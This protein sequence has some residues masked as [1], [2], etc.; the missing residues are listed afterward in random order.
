MTE[1]HGLADL[2]TPAEALKAVA[3]LTGTLDARHFAALAGRTYRSAAPPQPAATP[4]PEQVPEPMGRAKRQSE[5]EHGTPLGKHYQSDDLKDEALREAEAESQA[6]FNLSRREADTEQAWQLVRSRLEPA[7]QIRRQAQEKNSKA[8]GK[9]HPVYFPIIPDTLFRQI[10]NALIAKDLVSHRVDV[11]QLVKTVARGRVV[12]VPRLRR[13]GL[14]GGV[15]IIR[16]N[17]QGM[18]PFR[19][20]CDHLIRCAREVLPADRLVLGEFPEHGPFTLPERLGTLRCGTIIL[21]SDLNR[22]SHTY[23]YNAPSLS[24]WRLLASTAKA[25]QLD[26]RVLSPGSADGLVPRPMHPRMFD[27]RRGFARIIPWHERLSPFDARS[28]GEGWT[29]VQHVAADAQVTVADEPERETRLSKQVLLQ[30]EALA[31]QLEL[32][33]DVDAYTLRTLRVILAAPERAALAYGV[34]GQIPPTTKLLRELSP[35]IEHQVWCSQLFATRGESSEVDQTPDHLPSLNSLSS[36]Q[37][38]LAAFAVKVLEQAR[39]T[40]GLDKLLGDRVRWDWLLKPAERQFKDDRALAQAIREIDATTVRAEAIFGKATTRAISEAG[41]VE[42]DVIGVRFH[43]KEDIRKAESVTLALDSKDA[44]VVFLCP[45]GLRLDQ[46]SIEFWPV[47]DP[48]GLLLSEPLNNLPDR[49]EIP[50]GAGTVVLRLGG[51]VRAFSLDRTPGVLQPLFRRRLHKPEPAPSGSAEKAISH[52]RERK[53][54]AKWFVGSSI[55]GGSLVFNG[56]NFDP[57]GLAPRTRP[58]STETEVKILG[59]QRETIVQSGATSMAITHDDRRL[60]FQPSPTT[61]ELRS[62]GIPTTAS[63]WNSYSGEVGAGGIL[64]WGGDDAWHFSVADQSEPDVMEVACWRLLDV[65]GQ[66]GLWKRNNYGAVAGGQAVIAYENSPGKYEVGQFR[67]SGGKGEPRFLFVGKIGERITSTILSPDGYLACGV[68]WSDRYLVLFE[69]LGQRAAARTGHSD[70]FN[71]L[72]VAPDQLD[73]GGPI[74]ATL[75]MRTDR[76]I[77]SSEGFEPVELADILG[78]THSESFGRLLRLAVPVPLQVDDLAPLLDQ[79]QRIVDA[80][81][82]IVNDDPARLRDLSLTSE[83]LSHRLLG[84]GMT[85][86]MV[87]CARPAPVELVRALVAAGADVNVQSAIGVTPLY[88]A[89]LADDWGDSLEVLLDAGANPT[90]SFVEDGVRVGALPAAMMVSSSTKRPCRPEVLER[91]MA[92]GF[93]PDTLSDRYGYNLVAAAAARDDVDI[94]AR[95]VAGSSSAD[96]NY[97]SDGEW[98]PLAVAAWHGH[99]DNV[100][101]LIEHGADIFY[102]TRHNYSVATIAISARKFEVLQVVLGAAHNLM[103][104]DRRREAFFSACLSHVF[105]DEELADLRERVLEMLLGAG[106][107]PD[108]APWPL[109]RQDHREALVAALSRSGRK[110]AIVRT[111][112]RNNA[113]LCSN[114]NWLFNESLLAVLDLAKADENGLTLAHGFA[115]AVQRFG[116]SRSKFGFNM[117]D[118][119]GK[120]PLSARNPFAV[121]ADAGV[122]LAGPDNDGYQPLHYAAAFG[123]ERAIELLPHDPAKVAAEMPTPAQL[124]KSF[125]HSLEGLGENANGE[126]VIPSEVAPTEISRLTLLPLDTLWELEDR[127]PPQRLAGMRKEPTLPLPLPVGTW[128]P[129]KRRRARLPYRQSTFLV[130]TFWTRDDGENGVSAFVESDNG[131]RLFDVN[132]TSPPIHKINVE[133]ELD[134]AESE[135]SARL[136][137]HFFCCAIHGNDGEFRLVESAEELRPHM[138]LGAEAPQVNYTIA[139]KDDGSGWS[140]KAPMIYAGTYFE[141]ALEIADTGMV[142]MPD[143]LPRPEIELRSTFQADGTIFFR[144]SG[145]KT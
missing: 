142:E 25:L 20:D 70:S 21:L 140:V 18:R 17:G 90:A 13:R 4:R 138:R 29:H 3:E 23:G 145:T 102:L 78:S 9:V 100:R 42:G 104:T 55:A 126:L 134:I 27:P 19:L 98:T 113:E 124:A 11:Q 88:P 41:T 119:Q 22:F 83:E 79:P 12:R 136:Y 117:E 106:L 97:V 52:E 54:K 60:T 127:L 53:A 114:M 32:V 63:V 120:D 33:T 91:M 38:E 44:E 43:Y 51:E 64:L 30:K 99:V 116:R 139:R 125:G 133:R 85:L 143:D 80:I 49:W 84:S 66:A 56:N 35:L 81:C 95:I 39:A 58:A 72:D 123:N 94:L 105:D 34:Q 87:A 26:V 14:R 48:E 129:R 93:A 144:T 121:L 92:N 5:I 61:S 118:A 74:H 86:L 59:E 71:A 6:P 47:E 75:R 131:E 115:A 137:L 37:R 45:P 101:F 10:L 69:P 96:I 135:T 62:V 107:D 77:A 132:G 40:R 130:E 2:L 36:E 103:A 46:A 112:L 76:R 73:R 89:A 57:I 65:H 31:R 8:G 28:F 15:A 50:E 108:S 68:G 16:D 141:C 67:S 111:A 110:T 1:S 128:Q 7:R 82:A 24:D 122:D 109:A